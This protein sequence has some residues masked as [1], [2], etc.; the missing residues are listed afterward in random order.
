MLRGKVSMGRYT[1]A[2]PALC[3]FFLDQ[4]SNTSELI[5]HFPVRTHQVPF[6]DAQSMEKPLVDVEYASTKLARMQF[7][8][9]LC[10]VLYRSTGIFTRNQLFM[11]CTAELLIQEHRQ[12]L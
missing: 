9:P 2:F 3:K 10:E 8:K 5:S 11:Q 4:L 12:L 1:R 6:P 7:E